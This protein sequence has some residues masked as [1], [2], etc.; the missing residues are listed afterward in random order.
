[1]SLH[2]HHWLGAQRA[3]GKFSKRDL[4]GDVSEVYI[5]GTV[6]HCE[7][8]RFKIKPDDPDLYEVECEPVELPEL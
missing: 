2:K 7:C 5:T 1:M 3:V 4:A 6:T 8:G